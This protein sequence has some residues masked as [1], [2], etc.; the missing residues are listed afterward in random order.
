M[1]L[2]TVAVLRGFDPEKTADIAEQCWTIGM[3]L[4]EVPVQGAAGWASLE[5]I[6]ERC[7]GR[8]FGAGTVLIAQD[9]S[10]AVELGASVVISPG[11]DR[12][13]VEAT[14]AAGAVSLPGVMTAT[15]VGT[16]SLLGLTTCK[17]F[18]ASLAGP[19]WLKAMRGPFPGMRFVAVGGVDLGNAA[20]FLRA[21]ACG[22]GLGSSIEELLAL[23][24][25]AAFVAELHGLVVESD[26]TQHQPTTLLSAV[27]RTERELRSTPARE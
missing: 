8:P 23:D 26:S 22:V 24:D 6:A 10:R 16:A 17:A 21:G 12:A 15:E 9:A 14:S 20:A 18:P 4:V 13:V 27:G 5:T 3:D 2:R 19:E 7:A 1:R 11:I 25:P